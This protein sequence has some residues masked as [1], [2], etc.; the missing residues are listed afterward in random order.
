MQVAVLSGPSGIGKSTWVQ[1][2]YVTHMRFACVLAFDGF[3]GRLVEKISDKY[4]RG[5]R[6]VVVDDATSE[7]VQVLR[8]EGGMEDM[9]VI[10]VVT[11][12]LP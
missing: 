2:L 10:V 5:V 4:G 12:R 1:S 6:F 8:Q 7:V 11:E 3:T 9:R